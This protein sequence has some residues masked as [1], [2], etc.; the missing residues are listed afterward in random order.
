MEQMGGRG[1]RRGGPGKMDKYVRGAGGG[2]GLAGRG[3]QPDPAPSPSPGMGGGRGR[4]PGVQPL[5]WP[6]PPQGRAPPGAPRPALL[7]TDPAELHL[8]PDLFFKPE[9]VLNL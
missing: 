4:D 1:G 3:A 6:L 5:T 8:L 2:R 9:N 7:A